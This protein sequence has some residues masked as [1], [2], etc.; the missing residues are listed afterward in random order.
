M[1]DLFFFRFNFFFVFREKPPELTNDWLI[2]GL[3]DFVSRRDA[4]SF[5]CVQG[6]P[7]NV[8][9]TVGVCSDREQTQH[10]GEQVG[11][12]GRTG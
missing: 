7:P 12:T 4:I 8:L 9:E 1:C 3:V 10:N 5:F 2:K 6:L 11:G